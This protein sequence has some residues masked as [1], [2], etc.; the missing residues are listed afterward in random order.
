MAEE[1]QTPNVPEWLPDFMQ[2]WSWDDWQQFLRK[3]TDT[4]VGTLLA[5]GVIDSSMISIVSSL[6]LMGTSWLLWYWW[7]QTRSAALPVS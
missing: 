5:Y 3:I 1:K 7:N 4:V 2:L 6:V